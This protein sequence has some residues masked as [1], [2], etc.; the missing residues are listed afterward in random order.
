MKLNRTQAELI[1]KTISH[2]KFNHLLDEKTSSQLIADIEIQDFD[3][4]KLAKYSFWVSLFCI[5]TAVGA[6]LADK[7][8]LNLIESIFNAPFIVKCFGLSIPSVP[9]FENCYS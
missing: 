3:W 8:L 5:V 7:V 6:V 2:W 1:R 9:R 4:K